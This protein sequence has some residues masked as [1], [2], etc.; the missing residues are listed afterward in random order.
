[1]KLTSSHWGVYEF[2]VEKGRLLAL[3]PFVEDPDPSPIGH[4][5][6]NLLE[7]KMR[8]NTPVVRESWLNGGP[9]SARDRRGSDRFVELSWHEAETLVAAEL[10]RVI[11][12]KGNQAIYAGSYGWASA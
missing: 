7:D 1:M 5:I 2:V 9:G 3:K 10:N 4:S 8:I 6:I 11:K 12:L